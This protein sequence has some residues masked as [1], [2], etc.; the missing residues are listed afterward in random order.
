MKS[1]LFFFFCI[2]L[3]FCLQLHAG[4]LSNNGYDI[5]VDRNGEGD[6]TSIQ[7]AIETVRAFDPKGTVTIFIRNGI[8]KEK[9]ALP[10]Y[11][12]KVRI[13]GEN[14][15]KTIV[16]YDDHAKIN[17]MGTFRTYTFL[18]RGNDIVIENLTIENAAPPL[19]QAVALHLEGDRIV[20]RNCRLLGNQDTIYTGRE[21]S[22]VY[23]ENTYIEGTT[24]FIF[25]PSTC[26][27]ERCDIHCKKESYITAASTPGNIPFGYIFNH[28]RLSSAEGV[29]NVY[30]GRPWR[31][32]AMT[33]FMNCFLPESIHPLGWHNWDQEENEKTARYLEYNN[34][35][36]GA[37]TRQ[38]VG[39][40]TILSA[41]EAAFYTL[42]NVMKG[43]DNWIP[44]NATRS[45]RENY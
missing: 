2:L 40:T 27:F 24:D 5:V 31:A 6:F 35:G 30:L 19:A 9:V 36:K 13:V 14:R 3:P 10:T 45:E 21:N 29:S 22:R 7:E 44:D 42:Q 25:G 43:C 16:T 12:C 28:C 20:I 26:W 41:D 11:V 15:D 32:Y 17:N 18:I 33:L 1:T 23:F 34:S 38:R 37:E 8:Y 4:G 39:W